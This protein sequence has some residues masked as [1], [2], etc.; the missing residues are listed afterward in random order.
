MHGINVKLKKHSQITSAT[1]EGMERREANTPTNLI[2]IHIMLVIN[3]SSLHILNYFH[4]THSPC[5]SN[6]FQLS[7]TSIT[8][9]PPA[10]FQRAHVLRVPDFGGQS[11]DTGPKFGWYWHFYS[12]IIS[13]RTFENP[14][15]MGTMHK[16]GQRIYE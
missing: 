4:W 5:L 9:W 6:F 2:K 7:P 15:K 13:I 8:F 3:E 1:Y 16:P 12:T 14:Y 10:A 11:L